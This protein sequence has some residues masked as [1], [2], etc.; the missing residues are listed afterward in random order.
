MKIR[1]INGTR[2]L[3]ALLI[4]VCSVLYWRTYSFPK[5]LGVVSSKYG[6]AFFPRLLLGFIIV[7]AGVLLVQSCL[8]KGRDPNGKVLVFK[9]FQ[10]GRVVAVWGLCLAFY[11]AW[12]FQGYLYTSWFF[13]MALAGI[14]GIRKPV[15][16]LLLG[17][18]GPAMY[19]VFERFLHAGL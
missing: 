2:V 3:C 9:P 4:T 13:M 11:G 19:L 17:A 18:M 15:T 5:A 7:V 12:K 16:Y 6:S 10:V 14:L 8:K 1:V